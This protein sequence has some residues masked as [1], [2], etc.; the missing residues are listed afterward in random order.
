MEPP[1]ENGHKGCNRN[2][3]GVGPTK[4]F[5]VQISPNL[6]HVLDMQQPDLTFALLGFALVLLLSIPLFVPFGMVVF[7]LC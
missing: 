5:K 7:T 2:A 1:Q 4:P 6:P 3:I